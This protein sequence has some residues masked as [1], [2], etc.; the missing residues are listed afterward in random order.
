MVGNR[1]AG[2]APVAIAGHHTD[3]VCVCRETW[4]GLNT[5][6][7]NYYDVG[8]PCHAATQVFG[9]L[10]HGEDELRTCRDDTWLVL[11]F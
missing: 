3:T 4:C 10:R 8:G 6:G 5:N 9:C 7:V 11:N 1:R 2:C